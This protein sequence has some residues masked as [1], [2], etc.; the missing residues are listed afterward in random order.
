M[1]QSTEGVVMRKKNILLFRMNRFQVQD[2]S[3]VKILF[4]FKINFN[5]LLYTIMYNNGDA[6]FLH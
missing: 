3:E 1:V 6:N 2:P 5:I 4:S